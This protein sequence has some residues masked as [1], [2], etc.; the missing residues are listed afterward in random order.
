MIQQGKAVAV[1]NPTGKVTIYNYDNYY[2]EETTTASVDTTEET[3]NLLGNKLVT[4]GQ[5]DRAI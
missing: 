5:F 4:Q 1:F 3:D 2:R